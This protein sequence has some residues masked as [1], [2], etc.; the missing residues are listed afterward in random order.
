VAA[1][2]KE[3]SAAMTLHTSRNAATIGGKPDS[4]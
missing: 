2:A 4:M 3:E 1:D